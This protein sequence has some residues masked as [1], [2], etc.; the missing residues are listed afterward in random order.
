VK[1]RLLVDLEAVTVL[2]S[3]PTPARSRLLAHFVKLRSTPDQFADY[4]EH[5]AIGRRIEISVFAGYSI[6]YWID[7]ADRHVKILAVKSADR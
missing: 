5:D 2:H 1:Y 4:H 6:H 3:I 7:F